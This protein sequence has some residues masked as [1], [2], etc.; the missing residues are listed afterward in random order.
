M[1]W[2]D[3]TILFIW[4]SHIL[5]QTYSTILFQN[6]TQVNSTIADDH[7]PSLNI[8]VINLRYFDIYN[9][10]LTYK[11]NVHIYGEYFK[12]AFS[13]DKKAHPA[14]FPINFKH[15]S[16]NLNY[17]K[18]TQSRWYY[19]QGNVLYSYKDSF[20]WLYSLPFWVTKKAPVIYETL[21]AVL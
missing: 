15:C 2:K 4:V 11:N 7:W 17:F 8:Y 18:D 21:W 10:M 6:I 20:T 12:L 5:L 13:H 19:C 14:F 3:E 16:I 1:H 9:N